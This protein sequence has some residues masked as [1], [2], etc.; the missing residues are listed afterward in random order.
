MRYVREDKEFSF[1]YGFD[2]ETG[3][4]FR[5]GVLDRAGRDTGKNPFMA[6]FPHLIDVGI[7]GSCEHGR[8]GLCSRTS[9]EC[10]QS[11]AYLSEPNM[12]LPD[13]ARIAREC[14]GR[15]NQFALG[16]RGDPDMHEDFEGILRISRKAGIIPSFTTSGLGMTR[17]KAA[18]CKKY[19]GAVA[20][21]WYRSEYTI[22]ATQLLLSEGVRTNIHYV[23]SS[24]T[25]DEATERLAKGG[26][27]RGV[28]SVVFLLHKPRGQGSEKN[29]LSVDDPRT[30]AFFSEL[31]K[32]SHPHKIGMDSCSVPGLINC[33]RG[34]L[35]EAI[36]TCEGARFSC[37]ISAD[38][39]LMPC[40][41]D[42]GRDYAVSLRD[43]TIEEGWRSER[44]EAFRNAL[45]KSCPTCP[46]RDEC[47]GGCPLE[48]KV[49]LCD[50]E[51]KA[52]Y[53]E[54]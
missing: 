26:F 18:L 31:D 33:T 3:A 10:Y 8:L 24:E 19:C 22:R 32:G 6:S 38:M 30:R 39:Q 54:V 35:T 1:K 44:F 48:R 29:L 49:V 28:G 11:G 52:P 50:R 43:M 37:Y 4:Y 17:K 45:R 9:V 47:M 34:V 27:P 42:T 14:S 7:M 2:T 21:S 25:I 23:I 41:F 53:T 51:Y 40:S 20:V 12:T 36:D 15:V 5:T 46:D 16:G 13:F